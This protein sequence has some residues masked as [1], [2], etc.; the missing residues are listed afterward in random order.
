MMPLFLCVVARFVRD[1]YQ[2]VGY[3]ENSRLLAGVNL[4][5]GQ[6]CQ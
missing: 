3:F 1:N 6:L 4:E 5:R 2:F